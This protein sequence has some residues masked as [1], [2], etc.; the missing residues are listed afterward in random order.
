VAFGF[1]LPGNV[2]R[3][4]NCPATLSY[5][6]VSI[7]IVLV[8]ALVEIS[9]VVAAKFTPFRVHEPVDELLTPFAIATEIREP[10][11]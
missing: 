7:A 3:P 10:P 2:A 9:V 4:L 6:A 8:A 11:A 1:P 5:V